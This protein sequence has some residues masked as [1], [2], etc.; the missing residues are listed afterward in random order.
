VPE[1]AYVG[2]TINASGI[3]SSYDKPLPSRNLTIILDSDITIAAT[4]GT[5]GSY[6]VD[7]NLPY[8][9]TEAVDII[10]IYEPYDIDI[11]KYL[12]CRSPQVTINTMFYPTLL[13]VAAPSTVYPGIPFDISGE[14]IS[15]EG[16][17]DRNLTVS[18][19]DVPLAATTAAGEFNL[20]ISPSETT[21]PGQQRLTVTVSPAGRYSGASVSRI[22]TLALMPLAIDWQTP[23]YIFLPKSIRFQ[24]SVQSET[25]PVTDAVVN[26][27]FNDASAAVST[28]PDGS[29]TATL[30]APLDL[31]FIGRR[32]LTVEIIPGEPWAGHLSVSRS[33]MVINPAGVG[34]V[35]LAALALVIL[36]SR[37]R[38][39]KDVSYVTPGEVLKSP[40]LANNRTPAIKLTGIKGRIISAYRTGLII[41]EKISGIRMAPHVTLR[42]FL[43]TVTKV[44]PRITRPLT[45]LTTMAEN[46]LYSDHRPPPETAAT[47]EGFTADIKKELDRGAS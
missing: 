29:F 34:L 26:L 17:I 30:A 6:S 44:V 13:E 21:S 33:I 9:Y 5:D 43:K 25:G 22:V 35:L 8:K 10:S 27:A 36:A 47:A 1:T 4:T 11:E 16:N 37:K 3:L 24:G 28:A 45:E 42:E 14:I 23:S 41:I 15:G 12:A 39:I 18:L 20:E 46:A 32:E 40:V 2:E 38:R 19:D 31:S 7:I